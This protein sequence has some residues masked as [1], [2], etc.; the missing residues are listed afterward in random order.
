M[1]RRLGRGV[2]GAATVG[3]LVI[4][5][6]IGS[7][8][9]SGPGSGPGAATTTLPASAD[10][11]WVVNLSVSPPAA[12][13][14]ASDPAWAIS[15]GDTASNLW[16]VGYV[17]FD[18]AGLVAALPS[19]STVTDARLVLTKLSVTGQPFTSVGTDH[20][21]HVD[22]ALFSTPSVTPGDWTSL[23][24]GGLDVALLTGGTDT[25]TTQV[26]S[27][28]VTASLSAD[29]AALRPYS[30]YKL[31]IPTPTNGDGVNDLARFNDVEG[32]LGATGRPALVVQHTP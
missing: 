26:F 2:R 6:L 14:V 24:P 10:G 15:V 22:H 25:A 27:V 23:A 7:C 30:D 29:L 13:T 32:H 8:G 31:R 19:G 3:G 12:L 11:C 17:R 1:R 20:N 21:I 16:T 4:S 5:V 18:L 9:G 28:D